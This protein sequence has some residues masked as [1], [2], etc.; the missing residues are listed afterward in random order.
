MAAGMQID[1]NGSTISNNIIR[2]NPN[3]IVASGSWNNITGNA[4]LNASSND[5][6]ILGGSFNTVSG[7]TIADNTRKTGIDAYLLGGEGN[8]ISDN[9]IANNRNGIVCGRCSVVGNIVMNNTFDGI[10]IG[11]NNTVAGNIVEFNRYGVWIGGGGNTL[12]NN[13]MENN[14][15]NLKLCP[16]TDFWDSLYRLEDVINDVDSSNEVDGKPVYYWV[17][18]H[19]EQVPTNAGYLALINCTDI[20]ARNLT[21]TNNEPGLLLANSTNCHLELLRIMNNYDGIILWGSSNNTVKNSDV[22]GNSGYGIHLYSQ[23]FPVQNNTIYNN[24]FISNTGQARIYA[25]ENTG[26][27]IGGTEFHNGYPCGGNYWSDYNGT[28]FYSGPYVYQNET[29]SDGIGDGTYRIPMIVKSQQYYYYAKYPL[30][31]PINIFDAGT[32]NGTAYNVDIVS[33]STVSHFYFNPDEGAFV[34]FWVKGETETETL[35]FCRVAIPKELLWVDDGWTVL[36]GSAPLT[37][38]VFSDENC[39]S[40]YF[41]YTNPYQNVSTTV[42]IYG[43]H[44]IPEFPTFL[45][46]PI[47]MIH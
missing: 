14:L 43:T 41:T 19:N 12:R 45:I 29:G 10:D 2:N 5:G 30:M 23:S 38:R 9:F 7:N 16:P 37:Y 25:G 22:I 32:R 20:V 39:T 35:G 36:Y 13:V 28:D 40:L 11:Q 31:A 42:T 33:N 8:I 34:S 26:T 47:F 15:F 24:N 6:I 46:S 3:N 18:Q 17:D 44:T 27:S 4:I 1:S 21:L